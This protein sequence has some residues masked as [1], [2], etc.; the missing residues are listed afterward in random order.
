MSVHGVGAAAAHRPQFTPSAQRAN[1]PAPQTSTEST[2]TAAIAPTNGHNPPAHGV[3]RLLAEGHFTDSGACGPLVAK[4]GPPP[5]AVEETALVEGAIDEAMPLEGAEEPAPLENVARDGLVIDT[6]GTALDVTVPAVDPV[7]ELEI[8]ID[9]TLLD[10]PASE[11]PT[12]TAPTLLDIDTLLMEELIN[13]QTV[14]EQIVDQLD[15]TTEPTEPTEP[16]EGA[17]GIDVLAA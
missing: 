5:E 6:E 15:E 13:E 11:E 4:F 1:R 8:G 17:V 10:E 2:G 12:V 9:E 3:R 7:A 14:I 16:T